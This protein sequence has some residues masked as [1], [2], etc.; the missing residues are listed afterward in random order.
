[1]E[2]NEDKYIYCKVFGVVHG[3]GFRNFVQTLAQKYEIS[4]YVQNA[5]DR[6]V[7]VVANGSEDKLLDLVEQI[8]HGPKDAHVTKV[9]VVWSNSL[10]GLRQ[11]LPHVVSYETN[12]F[13]ILRPTASS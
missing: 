2:H 6:T 12:T 5:P 3:V 11:K 4:G 7:E 8:S 10:E 13:T 1:M 9:I